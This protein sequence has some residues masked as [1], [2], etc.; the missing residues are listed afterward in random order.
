MKYE[1]L[2]IALTHS[3]FHPQC[4]TE[5]ADRFRHELRV[6]GAAGWRVIEADLQNFR[7]LAERPVAEEKP[8]SSIKIRKRTPTQV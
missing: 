7:A 4:G 5:L 3:T 2:F 1:Y 6:A 8:T